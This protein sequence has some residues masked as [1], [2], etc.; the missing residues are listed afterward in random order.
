MLYGTGNRTN[1][2]YSNFEQSIV[3]RDIESLSHTPETNIV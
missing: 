1:Y 3:Y 2:F